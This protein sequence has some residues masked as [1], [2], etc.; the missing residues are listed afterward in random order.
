MKTEVE[1]ALFLEAA[2]AEIVELVVEMHAVMFV[3]AG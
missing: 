3:I 1:L 2:A